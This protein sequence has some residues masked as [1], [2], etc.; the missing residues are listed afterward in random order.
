MRIT[1]ENYHGQDPAAGRSERWLSGREILTK[2]IESYRDLRAVSFL[3]SR[4]SNR[5]TPVPSGRGPVARWEVQ[6]LAPAH[7]T[8]SVS[9][10]NFRCCRLQCSTKADRLSS[11][12]LL[13][14]SA[15]LEL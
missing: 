10:D 2:I 9:A 1:S 14:A 13:M 11:C 5:A 3:R 12:A 6:D 15:G 7:W 4:L 8:Y